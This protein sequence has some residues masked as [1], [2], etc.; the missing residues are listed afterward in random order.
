MSRV[1]LGD[2]AREHK[3]KASAEELN[4]LPVVGLEHLSQSDVDLLGSDVPGDTTFTKKFEKG[5]VLFGRRRAYLRK[6]SVAPFDGICSGDIIAIEAI[7]EKLSPRLLPFVIQ[8]DSLFD[9]AVENSAGSL[10]PRVKWTSLAN[11][12][13]DLPDMERQEKLADTLWACQ[14]TKRCYRRLLAASDDLIKSRFV[15]MFGDPRLLRGDESIQLGQV[16]FF[17][18]GGTPSTKKAEYYGG[19]IP[20]I[21]TVALGPNYID[22][23]S[24]KDFLTQ[25]GVDGSATHLIEAGS[26][27]VGHR[28]GVGKSSVNVCP[29]CTNQ[30]I[31]AIT[32]IDPDKYSPL[33]VKLVLD[34]YSAYLDSQ[35]RGATIKGVPTELIKSLNIPLVS[36]EK[37]LGYINFV[38]QVDKS[39]FQPPR[40]CRASHSG[41][42]RN[43]LLQYNTKQQTKGK[44]WRSRSKA[45]FT[46]SPTQAF[47]LL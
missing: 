21:S 1:R 32:E 8:S 17:I 25:K 33:F 26:V 23:T 6:A 12:E 29:I 11:Y 47:R 15:E 37:Q 7:G 46:S 4:E 42:H 16:G 39:E 2:V 30:D 13:F 35:K 38:H 40:T 43:R 27:L 18:N 45:L 10:S 44:L 9:F 14:E 41:S 19:D 28:V 36:L 5:H 24:A 3:G 34:F 22:E 31:V 20:W